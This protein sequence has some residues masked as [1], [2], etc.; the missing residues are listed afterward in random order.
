VAIL[1]LRGE[2]FVVEQAIA[3]ND[4]IPA[5]DHLPSTLHYGAVADDGE[6]HAGLRTYPYEGG[7]EVGRVAPAPRKKPKT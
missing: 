3:S 1:G 2:V 7:R 6:A 5:I 4:L